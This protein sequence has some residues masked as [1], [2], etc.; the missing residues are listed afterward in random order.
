MKSY[1]E[2]KNGDWDQWKYRADTGPWQDI[3][4]SCHLWSRK[5]FLGTNFAAQF[6]VL[7]FSWL[8]LLGE[9]PFFFIIFLVYIW[10]GH[11]GLCTLGRLSSVWTHF[12]STEGWRPKGHFKSCP[13]SWFLCQNNYFINTT[14][15]LSIWFQWASFANSKGSYLG[16]SP[17]IYLIPGILYSPSLMLRRATPINIC[18]LFSSPGIANTLGSLFMFQVIV[19]DS[20]I[21]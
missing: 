7:Y 15:F 4:K 19:G 20:F 5:C 11:W 3:V 21:K 2:N 6:I 18:F 10:S 13:C 12:L 16:T 9:S 8:D 17:F 1:W 14:V